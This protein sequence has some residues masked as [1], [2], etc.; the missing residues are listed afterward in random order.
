M[1]NGT[2]IG[3]MEMGGASMQITSS[4]GKK[5]CWDY[6][7]KDAA[8]RKIVEEMTKKKAR[9]DRDNE[10]A[11]NLKE[12]L[13]EQDGA[14]HNP[15]VTGCKCPPCLIKEALEKGREKIDVK[16]ECRQCHGH[17]YVHGDTEEGVSQSDAAYECDECYGSGR[18]VLNFRKHD[19]FK[20]NHEEELQDAIQEYL[21]T[22]KD[23]KK[24]RAVTARRTKVKTPVDCLDHH[25][26]VSGDIDSKQLPEFIRQNT[27]N[28]VDPARCEEIK[29]VIKKHPLR[30]YLLVCSFKHLQKA[31]VKAENTWPDGETIF[32]KDDNLLEF[33]I[34]TAKPK[35]PKDKAYEAGN[36]FVFYFLKGLYKVLR[37]PCPNRKKSIYMGELRLSDC[38]KKCELCHGTNLVSGID[39]KNSKTG[40]ASWARGM[41][42]ISAFDENHDT[43]LNAEELR[44]LITDLRKKDV[45]GST[46]PS[47][48]G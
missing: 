15:A 7:G 23:V 44:K 24:L 48:M 17:G 32:K 31:L 28:N 9:K 27:I 5:E 10:L 14:R 19:I 12:A 26:S 34:K 38:L 18:V 4:T 40:D 41:A 47:K 37:D 6:Y 46:M 8:M 43:E 36:R 35:L 11:E 22:P 20:A 13:K 29:A 2:S 3:I 30:N 25:S 16:E 45:F 1:G 33:V 21:F 39:I 42:I